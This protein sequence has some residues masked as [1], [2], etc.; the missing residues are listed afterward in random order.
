MSSMKRK[1]TGAL[2]PRRRIGVF[3]LVF[4]GIL[5]IISLIV[6]STPKRPA[7][8]DGP[9][10]QKEGALHFYD[11][12]GNRLLATLDIELANDDMERE[13]GLMWRRSMGP[14]QGMLFIMERSEPQSFWMLNTYLALDILFIDQNKRIIN[15]AADTRPNSLE[16]I[17]SEGDA[18]YV[19]EVNAG[20]CKRKGIKGG[21]RV[22]F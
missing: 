7:R 20:Y 13:R 3:S 4:V 12:K 21:D 2:N 14:D 6:M 16:P 18:L 15:I 10:F 19:L 11:G 22:E 17:S 9:H 1:K 8:A 5:T